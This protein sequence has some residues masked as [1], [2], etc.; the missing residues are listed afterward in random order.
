MPYIISLVFCTSV[1][2]NTLFLLYFSCCHDNVLILY[3]HISNIYFSE[4]HNIFIHLQNTWDS[5]VTYL[6]W[7]WI[8]GLFTFM[9][10]SSWSK[11]RIFCMSGGKVEKNGKNLKPTALFVPSDWRYNNSNVLKMNSVQMAIWQSDI[12]ITAMVFV[13]I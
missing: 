12:A 8:C 7:W 13:G 9:A 5:Q 2:I 1:I 10:N 6:Q 11:L 3:V 4:I